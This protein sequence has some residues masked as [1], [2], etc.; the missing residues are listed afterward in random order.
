MEIS[1][2]ISTIE[3]KIA[4]E[5]DNF[6]SGRIIKIDITTA[7]PGATELADA[8]AKRYPF[9]SIT[10]EHQPNDRIQLLIRKTM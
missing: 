1:Q 10:Y 6:D 2:A 4:T 5:R 7:W 3:Y 9:I 8:L